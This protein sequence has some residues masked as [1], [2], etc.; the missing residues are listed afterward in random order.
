MDGLDKTRQDRDIHTDKTSRDSK[1]RQNN[2]DTD[3]DTDRGKDRH[4]LTANST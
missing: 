4:Y 2:K 1:T 3:T